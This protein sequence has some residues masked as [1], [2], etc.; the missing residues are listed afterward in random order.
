VVP[1]EVAGKQTTTI[2]VSYQP[3]AGSPVSA[4]A[5]LN[6]V[7]TSPGLFTANASGSGIAAAINVSDYS[8]HSAANP[9]A[10]GSY[11][12]LYGT[13][14]GVESGNYADGAL[15]ESATLP[16]TATGP[17]TATVGGEKAVVSYYGGAP[18]LVSGVLQ[19]N[20]QIPA[21]LKAGQYPVVISVGGVQSQA[22]AM[23]AVK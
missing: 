3:A 16:V 14:D 8:I 22:T 1:H 10:A 23:L 12:A 5:Q 20:L 9:A 7:A 21:D 2:V 17:V 6:V 13:G 4:S 19:V 15:V 18:G 11:V